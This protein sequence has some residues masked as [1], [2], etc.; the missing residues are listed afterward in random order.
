MKIEIELFELEKLRSENRIM[1]DKLIDMKAKIEDLSEER[2]KDK[3][4]HLA[5]VYFNSYMECVF[6]KLGFKT[7]WD[8]KSVVFHNNL[9]D[10]LGSDWWKNSDKVDVELNASVSTHFKSAFLSIGVLCDENKN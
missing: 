2:I 9:I 7:R 6:E 3:A 5:E 4:L 10:R 8:K 1:Y